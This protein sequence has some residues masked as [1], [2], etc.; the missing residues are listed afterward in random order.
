MI[1]LLAAFSYRLPAAGWKPQ[2]W[3]EPAEGS[4]SA[5]I[6]DNDVDI[7]QALKTPQFYQLWLV[8][9]L[10]VTAGIGVLGV[11]RTMISEIFGSSLPN[12]VDASFA[13]SYVVMISV[14]NMI[15]RFIWASASDYIGRRNTYWIFFLLGIALYL[16]VP[17]TAQQVSANPAVI[18]LLYFYAATML[19]FTMYG[20]GFATIPAYLADIFGTRYVGGIHGRILTAWSTAG[21]LG[22]LAITSL[23]Q[24]SV[25]QAISD[26]MQKIDPAAFR[27]QFGAPV[28]QLEIL[29][30][31]NSV[32]IS[33]LMEIAPA[34]TVDPTSGLYNST[35]ILMAAL[36]AI[37]LVSNAL[38]RPVHSRHHIV[39][40]QQQQ[41]TI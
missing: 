5:L 15:G 11:A 33:R 29:I 14:F 19:I 17:Y 41:T 27:A 13:A 21:V 1:I 37:A 6:S 34:G 20:G 2:G 26:L 3:V 35:M 18:W 23:R 4:R 36:L 16:S 30:Q 8:L 12:I 31:Q 9:C 24:N 39:D 25:S 28:E 32:T 7:D 22:P 40:A 38:M 10:N